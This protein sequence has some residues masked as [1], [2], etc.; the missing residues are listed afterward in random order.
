MTLP[1]I[2]VQPADGQTITAN[3]ICL[4]LRRGRFG[5][6]KTASMAAVSVQ[7]DKKLLKL[8][9]TLLDSPELEAIQKLD[10]EVRRFLDT[11]AF[12]SMFKGG[13]YLIPVAMVEQ[14]EAALKEFAIR[15]R[16]LVDVAEGAYTTRTVETAARLDV[17]YQPTDY[18]SREAF[19]ACFTFEWHYVTFDTPHRLK[20]ISASLFESER[21]KAQQ[22][23][24]IVA[25]EC[26]Q[27]MRA[28]LADL[29]GHLV[30][31]LSPGDDGKP[32][33][34]TKTTVTN[35]ND[36]LAT[37]ELRNVTD[38]A[39]LGALVKQ[40]RSVITGVDAALLKS[41]ELVR[42]KVMTEMTALQAALEPMVSTRQISFDD[43]A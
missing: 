11:V 42:A 14:V 21:Q 36:F 22:K 40:A 3:T 33:R 30:D 19:K 15:R 6:Q 7:S 9:K 24:E 35:L 17:V 5:N 32:K 25:D 26:R 8:T 38:D 34:F 31:K 23:L 13:I 41:D 27:A 18:P 43:E 28:G 37:F 20:A 1:L 4:A 10:S 39:A 12:P 2:D 16:A 29:V